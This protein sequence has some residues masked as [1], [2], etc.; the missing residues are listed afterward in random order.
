MDGPVASWPTGHHRIE[1]GM[2]ATLTRS[3]MQYTIAPGH[4]GRLR[5]P[6]VSRGYLP[7]P[8]GTEAIIRGARS[9]TRMP[10][11]SSGAHG[12]RAWLPG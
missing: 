1:V 4:D 11:S 7:R 12:P 6:G 5:S 8:H 3:R 2:H 9:E 10:G